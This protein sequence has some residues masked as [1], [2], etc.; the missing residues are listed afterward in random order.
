MRQTKIFCPLL[1]L[2]LTMII[3]TGCGMRKADAAA[4][5]RPVIRVGVDT[6]PPYSYIGPGGTPIGIDIDLATEAFGRLGYQVE[7]QFIDWADKKALLSD[8]EIDCVWCCFSMDGREDEYRWAG[9]YM[10]SR[11]VVAVTPDSSITQLSDLAGKTLAVQA[12]TKP[13]E[14]FL[15]PDESGAPHLRRLFSLQNR[16]LIYPFLSKGYADAVAAHE[17]S[18]MQYMADYD[19]V[20]RILPE[21][22]MAVGLGAAFDL[23]DERGLDTAINT[24]LSEMRGDGTLAQI[25]GGYLPNAEQYLEVADDGR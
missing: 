10:V 11:Q 3:L 18:I 15:H 7:F 12:T 24:V 1:A 13:E 8:G 2:V 14:L 4:D 6:Y 5:D 21:P 20:Y 19:V 9:P 17:T 16:E 25:I 23:N 22:L